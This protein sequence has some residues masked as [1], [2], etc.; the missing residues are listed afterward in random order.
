MLYYTKRK[1]M[2]PFPEEV[3]KERS[4]E[5]GDEN[6]TNGAEV[7]LFHSNGACRHSGIGVCDKCCTTDK[8]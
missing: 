3:T 8:T 1:G 2:V 6:H 7:V 4:D 5:D